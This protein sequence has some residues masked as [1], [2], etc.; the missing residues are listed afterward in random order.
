M[1]KEAY[2]SGRI[3]YASQDDSREFI[4]LLACISAIGTAIPPLLIYKGDSAILQDTWLND[5][6]TTDSA[7]FATS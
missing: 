1:N 7:Y 5:Y 2:D 4:S 3:K 6:D